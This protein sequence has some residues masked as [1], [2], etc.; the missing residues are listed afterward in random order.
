MDGR[1]TDV[2]GMDRE[3]IRILSRRSNARGMAQLAV[4]AALLGGTGACVW[5]SRGSV[6]MAPAIVLYGIVLTFLFCAL[7]ETVHRTAFASRRANDIVAWVCGT[8][9][10]LPREYFRLFHFAHHRHTQDPAHD[11]EMQQPRPATVRSYV[12]RASGLPNWRQRLV[13][14]LRHALTAHVPEP[15]VPAARRG[16]IV[17]EARLL[18]G[19]YAA[20][21]TASL[22][23]RRSDAL[24]YW[25]LPAMAGQPFLRLYLLSEHAGCALNDDAFANT[26]TTYTNAVVRLLAWQMPF[27]V[28]HHAFPAIPFHALG[29]VNAH[30]RNRI[31][32][33]APG[34]LA[35][36]REL[37]RQLWSRRTPGSAA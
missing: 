36:H 11:P 17:R 13:V 16:S 19:C 14:T 12:W 8:L 21:L 5:A 7:H 9:L 33:S 6:W 31:R 32:V 10:L 3:T 28:E 24:I 1:A 23:F 37:V 18:W 22:I 25:I 15:F 29:K 20:V 34:Y 26:R 2:D 30:I 4:H 35:V 27:H